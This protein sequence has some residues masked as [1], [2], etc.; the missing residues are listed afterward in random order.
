MPLKDNNPVLVKTKDSILTIR[1]SIIFVDYNIIKSNQPEDPLKNKR[2]YINCSYHPINDPV[3]TQFKLNDIINFTSNA[4]GT[5]EQQ[6][7]VAS[8]VVK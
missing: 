1:N 6:P 8:N 3:C 5:Y 7:Q 4:N 2:I